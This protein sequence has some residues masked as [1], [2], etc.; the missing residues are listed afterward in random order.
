MIAGII[1]C[2]RARNAFR[3]LGQAAARPGTGDDDDFTF[4]IFIHFFSVSH[5]TVQISEL[6][7]CG[8]ASEAFEP[9]RRFGATCSVMR[10]R[11]HDRRT[12]LSVA[13]DGPIGRAGLNSRTTGKLFSLPSWSVRIYD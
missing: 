13:S 1:K 7:H 6:G 9:M 4:E 12:W 5:E 3:G 2:L 8:S 11:A 10:K